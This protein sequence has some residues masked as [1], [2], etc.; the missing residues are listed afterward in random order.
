MGMQQNLFVL[1]AHHNSACNL[2]MCSIRGLK[3]WAIGIGN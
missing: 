3:L 2:D 1:S